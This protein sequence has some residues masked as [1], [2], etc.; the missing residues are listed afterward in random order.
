[1][2]A[3]RLDLAMEIRRE[4]LGIEALM[5]RLL[6]STRESEDHHA[7]ALVLRDAIDSDLL[8]DEAID[9]LELIVIDALQERLEARQADLEDL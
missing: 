7:R 8:S 4:I 6:P 9:K 2:N 3:D 5:A 1:M